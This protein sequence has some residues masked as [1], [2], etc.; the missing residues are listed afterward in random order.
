MP[1]RLSMS[2]SILEIQQFQGALA[3]RIFSIFESTLSG[4][5]SFSFEGTLAGISSIFRHTAPGIFFSI[6][7]HTLSRIFFSILGDARKKGSFGPCKTA[8]VKAI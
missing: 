2:S 3:R 1:D 6:S 8:C 7:M 4:A 5:F